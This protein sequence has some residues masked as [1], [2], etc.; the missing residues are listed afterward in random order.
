MD[1]RNGLSY[2]LVYVDD[3]LFF[4]NE[5][6]GS[7]K[8]KSELSR[9]FEVKDLGDIKYCLGMEF[10]RK[11]GSIVINQRGYIR[12]VMNRFG[13]EDCKTVSTPWTFIRS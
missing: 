1:G 2:I 10:S 12:D 3:I 4:S 6:D 8:F 7:E 9:D 11:E 5:P 13:M